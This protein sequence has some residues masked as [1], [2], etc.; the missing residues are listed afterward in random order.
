MLKRKKLQL[1]IGLFPIDRH[2]T[3]KPDQQ[4]LLP[5]NWTPLTDSSVCFQ[6]SWQL[7][8]PEVSRDRNNHQ[9]EWSVQ[10]N[11]P[12]DLRN[13]HLTIVTFVATIIYYPPTR[14]YSVGCSQLW[15]A[16]TH[17]CS[18]SLKSHK[19][20]RREKGLPPPPNLS[21]NGLK[22]ADRRKTYRI[23]S[24]DSVSILST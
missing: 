11:L 21:M 7:K 15:V 10:A 20:P 14:A 4:I 8:K 17:H 24:P 13:S 23:I 19:L 3:L 5:N 6:D 22:P 16:Q 18:T 9:K 2:Q 12:A 1:W